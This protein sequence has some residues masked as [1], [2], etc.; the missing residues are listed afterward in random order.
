VACET[1]PREM[2]NKESD[3]LKMGSERDLNFIEFADLRVSAQLQKVR[4]L[5]GDKNA[6]L[7]YRALEKLGGH[8]I[9]QI[10]DELQRALKDEDEIVR[11]E[12]IEIISFRKLEIF[13]DDL[14]SLIQDSEEIVRA[15]AV[16]ALGS[17][18]DSSLISVLENVVK[19]NLS[20]M[21]IAEAKFALAKLDPQNR[22][23]W[24]L[25]LS[26]Q[27]NSKNYVVRCR[28]A[29]LIGEI[30]SGPEIYDVLLMLKECLKNESTEAGKSSIQNAINQLHLVQEQ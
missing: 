25:D 17:F 9:I 6:E 19:R 15:A 28:V 4:R 3:L 30:K 7:R 22:K 18:K 21:E 5:A 13:L 8:E 27:L 20:E 2:N 11:T 1:V 26:T 12:A 16:G 14:I 23:N 29:N 24:L 10:Q